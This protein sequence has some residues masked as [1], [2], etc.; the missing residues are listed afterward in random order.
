MQQFSYRIHTIS[1]LN[2]ATYAS[3]WKNPSRRYR[4]CTCACR[5]VAAAKAPVAQLQGCFSPQLSRASDCQLPQDIERKILQHT[6]DVDAAAH[7]VGNEPLPTHAATQIGLGCCIAT[8]VRQFGAS[9]PRKF[10]CFQ[11]IRARRCFKSKLCIPSRPTPGHS[12]LH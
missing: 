2:P 11:Q 9:S 6:S 1:S 5:K 12:G 8:E 7:V 10:T 3:R 4:N